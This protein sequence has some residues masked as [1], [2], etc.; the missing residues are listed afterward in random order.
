MKKS[1]V[2]EEV[3]AKLKQKKKD[4]NWNVFDDD[5]DDTRDDISEQSN[6][7]FATEKSDDDDVETKKQK[8]QVR[9]EFVSFRLIPLGF[10]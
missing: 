1:K 8:E 4:L 7:S 5:E 10:S 3:A 6:E 2:D 9:D